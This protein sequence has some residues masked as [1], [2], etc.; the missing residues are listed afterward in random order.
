[1][2][3]SILWPSRTI[4]D[5]YVG[6]IIE[7]DHTIISGLVERE[8]SETLVVRTAGEVKRPIEIPKVRVKERRLSTISLMPEGLLDNF[9]QREIADLIAF[10]QSAPPR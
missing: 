5:Q 1:M 7:T 2:L 6:T 3:E 4:S 10:L 8:D 9:T